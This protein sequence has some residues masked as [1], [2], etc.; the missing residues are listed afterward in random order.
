MPRR[1]IPAFA[2]AGAL[3]ACSTGPDL[4]RCRGADAAATPPGFAPVV[5]DDGQNTYFRFPGQ[6]RVPVIAAVAPDGREAAVNR[7][8]SGDV[9]TVHQVAP[10]WVLR[11]GRKVA[12]VTNRAYD[13][14]G[15]RYPTGTTSPDVE[16]VPRTPGGTR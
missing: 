14:V 16:R 13:Q 5:W 4:P 10:E 9:V 7:N 15:V 3:G 6:Q 2:L 11:D 1:T 8:T 12:C